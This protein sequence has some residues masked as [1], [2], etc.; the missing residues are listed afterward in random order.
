MSQSNVKKNYLYRLLY[1]ILVL[2]IPFVTTPYISRVLGAD[3]VG[4]YSYVTALMSYFTL[5][6]ALG[7][8]SYGSKEIAQHRDNKLEASKL[9]WEIEIM[10]IVTSL[11]CLLGWICVIS[12]SKIYRYY[13]LALIPTLLAIMFDIS[14]FYTGYEEVKHIV[15]CNTICKFV[16]VI[17]LFIL[18]KNKEDL[19]I[20]ILINSLTA[21][22]GNA[23]MWIYIPK[24]LASI[25]FK[26]L[27]IKRHIKQS[28]I[29]F[30]PSVAVSIYTVFDKTLIGVI[31]KD[32]LQNGYYEQANKAIGFVKILVFTSVNSVM[33]ARMSYLFSKKRYDEIHKRLERSMNFIAL[34]GIGSVFGVIGI[35]KNFVPAFFGKGYLPVVQLLY[36]LSPIVLIIGISNCLGTHYYTPAGYRKQSTKY[37]IVGS[38]V[39]LM[40]NLILI[41]Y[42]GANGAAIASVFAEL[43]ITIL[44]I[45]NCNQYISVRKLWGFIWKRLIAGLLMLAT[46]LCVSNVMCSINEIAIIIIQVVVGV[47]TYGVIL[48]ILKDNMLF[49]LLNIGVS[50]LKKFFDN[51]YSKKT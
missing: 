10:T 36:I 14:W 29:Y 45:H 1:E 5:F 26:E 23:S 32:T 51:S 3:G 41:P 4:T 24:M 25:D 27:S 20:Y 2:F 49:E 22:L 17:L 9:F 50:I 7:T 18:V 40:L 37:I 15:I 13:Y 8:S 47:I 11:V 42:Y 21:L 44:Y 34:V 28:M 39:N 12:F 46:V 43:V 19:K 35:A 33:G 38:C 6:A 16:G 30:I 31:T 48:L